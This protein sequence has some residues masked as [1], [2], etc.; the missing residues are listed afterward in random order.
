MS[1][2]LR[3]TQHLIGREHLMQG[4]Y[5]TALETFQSTLAKYG[6]HVGL[7]S[8]ITTCFYLLGRVQEC[9][10]ATKQLQEE[11]FAARELLNDNNFV[12]TAIFLGKMLEEQGE[13]AG[14]LDNYTQASIRASHSRHLRTKAQAQLLRLR[15][16]LGLH[17]DLHALYQICLQSRVMHKRIDIE[18]EHALMV[19]ELELFDSKI[20]LKRLA[21]LFEK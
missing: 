1:A 13:V 19:A 7:L 20:A 17:T 16:F 6:P 15:S 8:D 3:E 2:A 11:L 21:A 4:N 12:M 5:L 14:A 9:I 18:L 10:Q